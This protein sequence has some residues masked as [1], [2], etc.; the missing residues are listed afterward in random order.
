M[1]TSDKKKD[2]KYIFRSLLSFIPKSKSDKKN[3]I[4]ASQKNGNKNIPPIASIK[5]TQNGKNKMDKSKKQAK[6]IRYIMLKN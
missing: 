5:D 6:T 2:T 4:T 1:K 3:K